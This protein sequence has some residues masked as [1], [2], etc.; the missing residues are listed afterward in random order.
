M[1][2]HWK[3]LGDLKIVNFLHSYVI[4][5]NVLKCHTSIITFYIDACTSQIK[6]GMELNSKREKNSTKKHLRR[7]IH[8][9]LKWENSL[10]AVAPLSVT[11][12][13]EK[14]HILRIFFCYAWENDPCS[15]TAVGISRISST[16]PSVPTG[17]GC[18][19]GINDIAFRSEVV[20]SS[21]R[22][23]SRFTK[24]RLLASQN[25][26]SVRGGNQMCK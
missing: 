5:I 8:S 3:L 22:N 16:F 23:I 12:F 4:P 25:A 6:I 7:G 9:V 1:I 20:H 14:K 2:S 15:S 17:T 10:A 11:Y 19:C 18:V 21:N 26:L 24:M 13:L